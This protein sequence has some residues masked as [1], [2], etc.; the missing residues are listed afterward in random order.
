MHQNIELT[1]FEGNV[2]TTQWVVASLMSWG[3][4][5][6]LSTVSSQKENAEMTLQLLLA[7]F[8]AA[9][10]AVPHNSLPERSGFPIPHESNIF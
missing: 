5:C 2:A 3:H 7:N 9:Q 1:L 10:W 4:C 6:V 8:P